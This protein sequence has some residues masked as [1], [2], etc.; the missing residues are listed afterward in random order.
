MKVYLVTKGDYSDYRIEAVFSTKEKAEEY[1]RIY[2]PE[3]TTE[4][5]SVDDESIYNGFPHGLATWWVTMAEDGRIDKTYHLGVPRIDWAY[6]TWR[7][8]RHRT[9]EIQSGLKCYINAQPTYGPWMLD[10][11]VLARDEKHAI[12]IVNEKRAQLIAANLWGRNP[13]V[14]GGPSGEVGR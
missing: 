7:F 3:G 12:K 4:E 1:V 2:C 14:A 9:D 8:I 5:Y 11:T 10:M 6:D 13:E